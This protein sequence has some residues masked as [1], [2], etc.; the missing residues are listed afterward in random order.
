MEENEKK[1]SDTEVKISD[2][3]VKLSTPEGASNVALYEDHKKLN[4][5]LSELSD[6]WMELNM[7]LEELKEKFN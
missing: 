3:E 1:I 4:T 5:L 6:K 2:L 7:Q